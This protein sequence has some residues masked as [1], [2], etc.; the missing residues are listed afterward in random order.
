MDC[1]RIDLVAYHLGAAEGEEREAAERHLVACKDCLE[2]YLALKRDAD[3]RGLERPSPELLA[4]LRR[5]VARAFAPSRARAITS[6]MA[7]PI[8]LYQG[9]AAVAVLALASAIAGGALRPRAA[10]HDGPAERVDSSRPTAE[11]LSIY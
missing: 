9:I 7:R 8:P 5:D 11:S 10:L 6:W 2:A 3:R 1:A 4:R